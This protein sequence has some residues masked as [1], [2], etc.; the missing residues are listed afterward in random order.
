MWREAATLWWGSDAEKFRNAGQALGIEMDL[1]AKIGP[2]R[3]TDNTITFA[4]GQRQRAWTSLCYGDRLW[5]S[6]RRMML[7]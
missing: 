1:P 4:A 5:W 3:Y 6:H 2:F 7:E